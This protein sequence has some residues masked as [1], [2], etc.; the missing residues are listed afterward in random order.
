MDPVNFTELRTQFRGS[1]FSELVAHHLKSQS[2]DKRMLAL[3]GMVT[4]LP[5]NVRAH[6]ETFFDRWNARA[7]DQTLWQTDT[8]TIFD[9][10][11]TDAKAFFGRAGMLLEDSMLFMFFNMVLMTYVV[12]AYGQPAMREFMGVSNARFPWASALFLLYPVATAVYGGAVR[13]TDGNHR[14]RL[15]ESWFSPLGSSFDGRTFSYTR[16]GGAGPLRWRPCS[17]LRLARF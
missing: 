10:V 15:G 1:R 9:E 12:H 8:A 4:S 3:Y 7:H 13:T 6:S 16:G 17:P 11:I 5:E 14:L 2:Q